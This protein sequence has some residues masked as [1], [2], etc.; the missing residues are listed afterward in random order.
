M[1]RLCIQLG[2]TSKN[3]MGK[4]LLIIIKSRKL[5]YLGHTM[6]YNQRYGFLQ[7]ILQENVEGKRSVGKKGYRG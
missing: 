1:D 7:L 2:G 5:E 4:K 3:A 6:S